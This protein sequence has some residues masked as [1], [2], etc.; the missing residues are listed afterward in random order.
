[1][2]ITMSLSAKC[3]HHL[4]FEFTQ[5]RIM[6][7]RATTLRMHNK[8]NGFEKNERKHFHDV[9][10]HIAFISYVADTFQT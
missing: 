9:S 5:D 7:M 8:G 10:V 4:Q 1:M 6:K 2:S 3:I